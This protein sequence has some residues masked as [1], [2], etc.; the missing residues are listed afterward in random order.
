MPS[1]L[2]YLNS[3]DGFIF[4]RRVV[5]LVFIGNMFSR[6]SYFNA[7]SVDPDQTPRYAA[8][9]LG[10]RCLP[11]SLLWDSRHKRVNRFLP[12]NIFVYILVYLRRTSNKPLIESVVLT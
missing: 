1:G 2:F 3:L 11:M 4:N 10:L 7:N 12:L 8:S 6:N 9:D 5:W